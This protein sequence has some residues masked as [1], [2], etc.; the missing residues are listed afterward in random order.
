MIRF[1][2]ICSI[3]FFVS[4]TSERTDLDLHKRR[5]SVQVNISCNRSFDCGS[6]TTRGS[7]F[8]KKG[9]VFIYIYITASSSRFVLGFVVSTSTSTKYQV[10]T[11]IVLEKS[12]LVQFVRRTYIHI[13]WF[14]AVITCE[15]SLS[16]SLTQISLS[17]SLTQI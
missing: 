14:R 17:D 13:S 7:V 12:Y 4:V 3:F 1:D 9:S 10:P 5:L 8:F 2:L 11:T 6:F 16:D 15:I